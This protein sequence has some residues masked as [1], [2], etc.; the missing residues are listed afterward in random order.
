LPD[1]G[2]SFDHLQDFSTKPVYYSTMTKTDA[3]DSHLRELRERAGISVRELA[4]LL[5]IHHTNIVY[6]EKT[7]RIANS[8]LLPRL[9]SILGVSVEEVLGQPRPKRA[10][11]VPGK[12]A[13]VFEKASRLPRRQQEK[14]IEFV[15]PFIRERS[16]EEAAAH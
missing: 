15:E 10:P 5:A 2:L 13:R 9:A 12:L 16:K 11:I 3:P 4:R 7:G 6:W 8:E 1:N 14:I